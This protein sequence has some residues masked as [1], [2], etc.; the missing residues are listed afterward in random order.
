MVISNIILSEF[1]ILK[2]IKKFAFL[3]LLKLCITLNYMMNYALNYLS[4][5]NFYKALN[6]L[7]SMKW[8]KYI[9]FLKHWKQDLAC[10]G[11]NTHTF[12]MQY[13]NILHT[14]IESTICAKDMECYGFNTHTF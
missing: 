12:L 5:N 9:K 10:Y 7:S 2:V 3:E 8:Y 13:Q 14:S 6:N 11:L 4:P 1:F